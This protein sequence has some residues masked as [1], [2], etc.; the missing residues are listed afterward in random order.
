MS[1]T[2]NKDRLLSQIR[3]GVKMPPRDQLALAAMLSIPSMLAQLVH[4]MMQYIDAS[5]V[6][7][8]GAEA[9]ASIGL[10]S[11]TIW[12]FGSLGS[13]AG[14]GFY[15]QVAHRIGAGE[16]S[17]ARQILRQSFIACM[18]FAFILLYP[19]GWEETKA[20]STT[21]PSIS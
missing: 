2:E 21:H 20:F 19:N 13:A 9:S 17:E 5:M 11:T 8:L 6:G 12:L 7:S 16:W 15:V 1:Y 10:V 3:D 4:I 18:V 14:V